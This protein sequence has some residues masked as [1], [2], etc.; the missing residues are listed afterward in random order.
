MT[1]VASRA[2][3]LLLTEERSLYL[4][5]PTVQIRSVPAARTQAWRLRNELLRY[6]LSVL[7]NDILSAEESAAQSG[8]LLTFSGG[9]WSESA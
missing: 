9:R 4:D 2:F 8:S 3:A 6:G 7:P 5:P 1:G